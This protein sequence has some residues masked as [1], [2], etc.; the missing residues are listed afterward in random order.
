MGQNRY[1]FFIGANGPQTDRLSS[2]RYAERDAERLAA[3]LTAYPCTFTKVEGMK[4]VSREATLTQL[5]IFAGQCE[6]SDVLIVHFS[7]H[8]IYDEQLYLICNGSDT[9]NLDASAIGVDAIKRILQR[10]KARHKLLVLDCC[11]AG[12]AFSG[13]FKGEPDIKGVLTQEF[14]GSASIILSAC[15]RLDRAREVETLDGGAGFLSWV[16][17]ASCTTHF[18][19]VS[20]DHHSLSLGDIWHWMPKALAEV[21]RLL[22]EAKHLPLPV[23]VSQLE[24]GTDSDIWLTE[25]RR[26]ARTSDHEKASHD[27]QHFLKTLL[28]DHSSFIRSRLDSFVGREKELAEIRQRIAE[29]QPTGGYLTITGQAGQGKSSI[30]A[31][32]VDSY[33]QECGPEKIAFHFIPF[34][35]G[36]DHQVGLLRNIMA[37]LVL[38]Y[39][40][41]DLYVASESRPALRDYFPKVLAELAAQGGKEVIF[42]DG[43]DQLEEDA[44]GLRDLSFLPNNP[45]PG[46]VFVLGT[47]PNDTL[48]PLELLK[49]RYEYQLPNLSREDFNLILQHRQVPLERSLADRFYHA[50]QGNA[51]Y[52]DLLAKELAKQGTTASEAFIK[53]VADNPEHLFSL[54]MT[55]L[56]RLAVE[57]REIIKPLLGVL[58]VAQ[59]PLGVRHIRQILGVD[60][61]RLREGIERLGGLIVRDWQERYSL[62]HLKLYEYLR[63]DEQ[64]PAKVY[65]FATDEEQ[66][67]HK[68]LAQWYAGDN[69][70]IIWQN[71]NNNP[72]E[73][74]QRE[75]ARQ[76]YLTHLY[77]AHEWQQ[78]FE[79]LDEGVY[80]RGKMRYDPS[81]RLYAQDLDLG[82]QAAAWEG[83][84]LEQ[85]SALL[86]RLWQYTFLR[87]SLAS[88]AD[89]YPLAAFRILVLLERKQEAIGLTE[90]LTSPANKVRAL[91]QITEPLR[92]QADQER[93]WLEILLRA[94]DVAQTIE[95]SFEQ[96]KALLQ[97]AT[98]LVHAKQ[99]DRAR[100]VWSE[101]ER[102]I[103]TIQDSSQQAE[104]LAQLGAA[105]AHAQQWTQAERVI[106]T[107]Q[108][109]YQ[110]AEALAQLGAALAQAQQEQQAEAVWT[111]AQQVIGTIEDRDERAG[112]L[113]ELATALAQAQLWTQAQQVIGTIEDSFRRSAALRELAAALAQAQQE[114]Q[115]EA[116]WTQAQQVIGTI[117][118]SDKRTRALREL[119]TALAQARLWTQAQQ[120]IGTIKDSFRRSAALRELATALAQA[121]LWTQA[122]Q[123]IGTIEDSFRRSAALRELALQLALEGKFEQVLRLIQHSWWLA[124]TRENALNLFPIAIGLITQHPELGIALNEA[125]TR[126]DSFLKG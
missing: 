13:P 15:S 46:V 20:P 126:V 112:A 68:R 58:L 72:E 25:A 107:I 108:H 61:D 19:E 29:K 71:I 10:S 78:L 18:Q 33:Q 120:V 53:Q 30:I 95:D 57:W 4:A 51:L 84:T 94:G 48:R 93:D 22:G 76:Y 47:R 69:L 37:R 91:L 87:C 45:S 60:D 77:Q 105:L 88:R 123:V 124:R 5:K 16:L 121:Q 62:F 102:M 35:P 34:N 11:Y 1:A 36:P 21:N 44:T 79:V 86:P 73:Q 41:S 50:M 49:P 59:E 111:Q 24:A 56:K 52:L 65:I 80:G 100:A 92:E 40:L 114:Q 7:G 9:T 23:L 89:Q 2:L 83:W 26:D 32:L 17:L 96:A 106:A 28:A 122:Q 3:A 125:F 90:L 67:W 115:A 54:S 6:K 64:R 85:G 66:G 43:L 113:C 74:R 39:N 75:Y 31:K 98:S 119:A 97:L 104:A 103:A 81:T 117:E 27:R 8:G 42:I 101:A 99:C 118:N 38:K 70:S 55:R 14:E 63:Q 12:G 109:S 116:V 110:Q 82:R